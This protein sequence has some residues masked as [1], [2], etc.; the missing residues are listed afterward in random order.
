MTPRSL[1]WERRE[2]ARPF[3]ETQDRESRAGDKQRE[4][5]REMSSVRG[6]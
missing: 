4:E 3:T 5:D 6:A 1:A 2:R